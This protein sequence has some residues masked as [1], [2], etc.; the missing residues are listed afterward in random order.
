[1]KINVIG[2][3]LAGC[4]AAWQLALRGF[5]VDL[6]EMRGKR[7][8]A[9]HKTDNLAELVCSNSFRSD[10]NHTA[11]G[12]LHEELRIANSLIMRVADL[13]KV[14]AGS[15]LAV[16]RD[17][18]AKGVESFI[19]N[20]ENI[21]VIREE[22]EAIPKEGYSIIASGPLTSEKLSNDIS[23]LN[24]D[25]DFLAFFDAISP[26][27]YKDSID[28]DTCW[29]QSRY[30]KGDGKDYINCPL[31]EDEYY[32]FI[33]ELLNSE[34]IEFKEWEEN[35]PYFNGCLPVEIM[36]L[37]GKDTLRFGPMKPVGLTNPNTGK[38]SFAVV[39]LRQDNKEGSLYN[40][41]GFQ[42]KMKYHE[43][44]RVLQMIPGLNNAKFA[45]FG[46]MHRNTFINSR[47]LLDKNL[48]V[49]SCPNIKFAGQITGV[50]GYVESTAIGLL[51]AIYLAY[52]LN[53][54]P[55]PYIFRDT[56]IGSLI[57]YIVNEDDIKNFQPMNINFGLFPSMTIQ[58]GQNKKEIISTNALNSIKNWEPIKDF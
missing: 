10:D 2:G 45:R 38:R 55:I 5:K 56:A 58:K 23:E 3:G 9:A 39:Q 42:T 4:E 29:F 50:E 41:V 26:I 40:I 54:K 22:I 15:A 25:I 12:I 6:Y 11:I 27:I 32:N 1:M 48:S 13:S 28:F 46:G 43:Q 52:E 33:N 36:A 21:T 24:K 37:R 7:A 44:K 51:A 47:V 31:N 16:D 17:I 14:P 18:F 35:T 34:K 19:T 20:H 49:K 57:N 8:T 53:E 30:D